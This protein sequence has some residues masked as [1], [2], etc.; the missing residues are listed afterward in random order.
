M[1]VVSANCIKDYLPRNSLVPRPLPEGR[2]LG[3]RLATKYLST[4]LQPTNNKEDDLRVQVI[5]I[6]EI[7]F[8]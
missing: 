2:G 8:Q 6:L 3:M 7:L 5:P 4:L 1:L